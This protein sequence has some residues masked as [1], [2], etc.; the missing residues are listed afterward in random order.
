LKRAQVE[1][2]PSLN[3]SVSPETFVEPF[4]PTTLARTIRGERP[5]FSTR[6]FL[7][8]PEKRPESFDF[9]SEFEKLTRQ[10]W[11]GERLSNGSFTDFRY[12][13]GFANTNSEFSV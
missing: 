3:R 11:T 4:E 6:I 13:R 9:I 10:R 5:V 2:R 7:S 8:L 1:R 12:D